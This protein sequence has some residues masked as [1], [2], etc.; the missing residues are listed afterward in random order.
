MSYL[1]SLFLEGE[2]LSI[3][4]SELPSNKTFGL[5]FSS[6]FIAAAVFAFLR[7]SLPWSLTFSGLALSF[8]SLALM[9]SDVLLPLNKLWMWLGMILGL[10]LR[11]IV[12]AIIF[13]G[14]FSPIAILMRAGRRDALR[15]AA[16]N[17]GSYW[18]PRE[19]PAGNQPFDRQF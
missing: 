2:D 14:L 4:Q 1:K 12:F 13:F 10:A 18:I 8:V 7:G 6:V 15:L 19:T 3:G 16:K 9:K 11:P 5:F 17:T